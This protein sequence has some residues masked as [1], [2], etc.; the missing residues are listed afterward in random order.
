MKEI[1]S[2]AGLVAIIGLAGFTSKDRQYEVVSCT[3][4]YSKFWVAEYS[5]SG[6][7]FDGNPWSE[8]WE[9]VASDPNTVVTVNGNLYHP[10]NAAFSY[11]RSEHGYFVPKNPPQR[12]NY[13][14]DTGYEFDGFKIKTKTDFKA[15]IVSGEDSTEI[16]FWH[17]DYKKCVKSIDTVVTIGTWY[18]IAHR[19]KF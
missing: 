19:F 17:S 18:G 14:F 8:Y 3:A 1:L 16:S 15:Y 5:D 10:K 6:I 7:D 2:V 9:E 13:N 12:Y 4:E 11:Y